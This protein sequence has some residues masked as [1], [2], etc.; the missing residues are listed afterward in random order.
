MNVPHATSTVTSHD[1]VLTIDES[2]V[3][4]D[5]NSIQSL[6]SDMNIYHGTYRGQAARFKE[7]RQLSCHAS[8]GID[9]R[10]VC[11]GC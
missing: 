5:T 6:D 2:D 9:V 4:I 8:A 10:E 7:K 1:P 3:V 11:A